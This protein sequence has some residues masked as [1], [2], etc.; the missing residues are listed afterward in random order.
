MLRPFLPLIDWIVEMDRRG[1][2]I[3]PLLI[4]VLGFV[5]AVSLIYDLRMIETGRSPVII[6]SV[7]SGVALVF[8]V[9]SFVT[10]VSARLRIRR[11]LGKISLPD[12]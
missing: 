5:F 7:A 10:A 6:L 1:L 8:A 3:V 9:V 12:F 11:D 4:L 2:V